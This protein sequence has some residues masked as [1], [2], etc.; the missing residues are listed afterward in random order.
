[1]E[2]PWSHLVTIPLYAHKDS[3]RAGASDSLI[4]PVWGRVN[5][6]CRS[7]SWFLKS[8]WAVVSM[9]CAV[10][11]IS[12]GQCAGFPNIPTHWKIIIKLERIDV[13]SAKERGQCLHRMQHL[14]QPF[15][16]SLAP[17]A[18]I[19]TQTSAGPAEDFEGLINRA[20]SLFVLLPEQAVQETV[21]T[22]LYVRRRQH[23][24]ASRR[25]HEG[26]W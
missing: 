25:Y 15:Q 22:D 4:L 19:A 10:V 5:H 24:S 16:T 7:P 1:M 17:P 3:E 12:G 9:C 14:G 23:P 20:L 6:G 18:T 13:F 2:W 21:D 11:V 26:H 8:A